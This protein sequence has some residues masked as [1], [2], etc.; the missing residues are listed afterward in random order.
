MRT[1]LVALLALAIL[2]STPA[3]A[4]ADE[5]TTRGSEVIEIEGAPPPPVVRPKAKKPR[6]MGVI[7]SYSDDA[8]LHNAW[9]RA[10]LLLDIDASGAVTRLKFLHRP[11][12]DLENKAIEKAFGFSFEP[13]RDADGKAIQ[14]YVIWPLEWPSYWWLVGRVGFVTTPVPAYSLNMPCKGSGEPLNLDYHHVEYRDCSPPD[15]AKAKTEPWVLP[16]S[17]K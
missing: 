7:P 10:W 11:G 13:A 8:I 3:P 17:K 16:P 6:S 12:H 2:A 15:I 4:A 14:S 1:A 5:P 9:E